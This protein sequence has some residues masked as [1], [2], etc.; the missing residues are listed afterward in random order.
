MT[1]VAQDVLWPTDSN[2]LI[3]VGML[4]VGQ[5]DAS[6]ILVKDRSTYKTILID[7][8]RDAEGCNGI[9]VPKLM[10]DLLTTRPHQRCGISG[11]RFARMASCVGKSDRRLSR[12][13][14]MAALRAVVQ[15]HGAQRQRC[16]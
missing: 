13:F 11:H 9:N 15:I 6:V 3:R 2:V 10:K 8:N 14:P 16:Q 5:G 4:Y 1:N 7:I 12:R